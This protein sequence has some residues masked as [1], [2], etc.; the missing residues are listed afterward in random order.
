MSLKIKLKKSFSEFQLNAEWEIG[1]E[2][3][4]IFGYSGAGKSLTLRMI[5]GLLKPDEGSISA[6]DM[7]FFEHS[8]KINFPPQKRRIGYVFQDSSLFPH[9][10]VAENIRYG[11]REINGKAGEDEVHRL[12]AAFEIED[13]LGKFPKEISGG[14]KQRVAF[15]RALIGNP[16]ALLLD[17]PFSALDNPTRSKMRHFLREVQ[18]KFPIP[19]VVVTHD[20]FE[21]Y[22]LA[23]KLIVYSDGR[24]VQTGSPAEVFGNPENLQVKALVNVEELCRCSIFKHRK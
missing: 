14:Q 17:E 22:S 23:E 4:V 3:G 13:L 1:K 9:F 18:A 12:A 21:A 20:V 15:A 19:I 5:A 10:S 6:Q 8:K 16:V 7:V 2:I 24:V 11:M